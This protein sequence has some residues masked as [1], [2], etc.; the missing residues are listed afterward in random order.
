M[1]CISV[2]YLVTGS[3]GQSRKS[4]AHFVCS[5]VADKIA[6]NVFLIPEAGI[7]VLHRWAN[8]P[9]LVI[10]LKQQCPD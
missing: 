5:C 9:M 2:G 6:Q 8:L 3:T 1:S 7:T 4:N 10:T